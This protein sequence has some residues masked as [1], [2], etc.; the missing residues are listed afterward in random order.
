MLAEGLL[1]KGGIGGGWLGVMRGGFTMP[2]K[3]SLKG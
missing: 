3:I 1:E 2:L